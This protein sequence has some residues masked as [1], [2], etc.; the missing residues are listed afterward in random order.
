MDGWQGRYS[1]KL[2]IGKTEAIM[3]TTKRGYTKPRFFLENAQFTLKEQVRYLGVELSS[4]FVF[5]KHLECAA[6][7]AKKTITSLSRLMPNIGGPK[8]KNRQLLMSVAQSQM[9]YAAPM[10]ASALRFEKNIRTHSSPQRLM[11]I[12]VACAYRT[13]STNAINVMARILPLK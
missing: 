9:L 12:R 10:W 4:K 3:L 6:A 2:S 11:A 8:Q 1:V 13:V 5:G 7:K